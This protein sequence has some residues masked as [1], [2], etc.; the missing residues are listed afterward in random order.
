MLGHQLVSVGTRRKINSGT[1]CTRNTTV[2]STREQHAGTSS[3]NSFPKP[4]FCPASPHRQQ[5]THTLLSNHHPR[6]PTSAHPRSLP[7]TPAYPSLPPPSPAYPRPLLPTPAYPRPLL[8]TPAYP[9]PL[10][11][12]LA[13]TS[14]PPPTPAHSRLPPPTPAQTVVLTWSIFT[15]PGSG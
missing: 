3:L 9:R 6:P 11:P 1:K 8:P 13:Y 5:S 2:A 4:T 15:Q 7:P 10:P 12:T 14:L